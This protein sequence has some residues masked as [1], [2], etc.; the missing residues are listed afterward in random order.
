MTESRILQIV[1]QFPEN[2]MKLLLE[3][4]HNVEDLLRLAGLSLVDRIDFEQLKSL[5]TTF[6]QRDFQHVES[7]VLLVAP[8]LRKGKRKASSSILVYILIEQQTQPDRCAATE[9]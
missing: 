1:R 8:L 2:G 7:D 3:N 9:E 5:G 6:I 4:P